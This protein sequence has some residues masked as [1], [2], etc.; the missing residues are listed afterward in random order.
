MGD[1]SLASTYRNGHDDRRGLR[2]LASWSTLPQSPIY[3]VVE[4]QP[5]PVSFPHVLVPVWF[6]KRSRDPRDGGDTGASRRPGSGDGRQSAAPGRIGV[7]RRL[8]AAI[9]RFAWQEEPTPEAASPVLADVREL[10][11]KA[12]EHHARNIRIETV[13]FPERKDAK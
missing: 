7:I 3:S 4:A 5:A 12:Q 1:R 11:R 10:R 6:E 2:P 13:I 9:Y 8:W